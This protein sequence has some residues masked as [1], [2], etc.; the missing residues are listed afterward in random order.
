M[1]DAP[2]ALCGQALE[3]FFEDSV[4]YGNDK[5]GRVQELINKTVEP[6][7]KTYVEGTNSSHKTRTSR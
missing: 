7:T 6:L 5:G 2:G 4:P 1:E 3:Q